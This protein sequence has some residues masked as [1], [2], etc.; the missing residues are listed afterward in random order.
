MNEKIKNKLSTI[1][2]SPGVYLMKDV[3][4]KIIY[5]GKAVNLKNRVSTYFNNSKKQVKVQAMVDS[6][7]NFD[8]IVVNS[9]YDALALENNLIKKYKPHYNILLKDSKTFP[10]IKLNL[11]TTFPFFEMTRH[12]EKDGAKYFGPYIGK[13][14]AK[15]ILELINFA[16]ELRNCKQKIDDEKLC[17][18]CLRYHLGNCLAPCIVKKAKTQYIINVKDA[19]D[20]LKGNEEKIV[21][22]L[23]LKMQEMV[24]NQNYEKAIVYR[25]NIR[26]LRSL[27]GQVVT[28]LNKT[29][30]LDIFAYS[31][32][33]KKI[34][35]TLCVIRAGKVIG[36]ENRIISEISETTF[37]DYIVQ[38]YEKNKLPKIVLLNEEI[39]LD[40]K[41]FI[42]DN[43]KV[44]ADFIVPLK[45]VKK[46]LLDMTL[47]NSE[48]TFIK[49]M[50]KNQLEENRTIN[51]V[52]NLQQILNL[53]SPPFR[54]EC[55]DVSHISGEY[56]VASMVVFVNG[57][58]EK[59]MYRKF[60]I[61]SVEGNNDFESLKETLTRRL[62]ELKKENNKDISLSVVPNLII[63]DGGKGQLSSVLEAVKELDESLFKEIPFIAIAKKEEEIFVP[64]KDAPVIISKNKMELQLIQRIRDESHRFAIMFHR[65]L[66]GKGMLKSIFDDITGVGEKKKKLL[67][68]EFKTMEE[69]KNATIEDFTKIKGINENLAKEIYNKIH[70]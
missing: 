68:Q 63:L 13:Y 65:S 45:G 35:I 53:P 4:G 61:K 37:Q 23:N 10:Y 46:K 57:K 29:E 43:S 8:Y 6:V 52:Y 27:H 11:N 2:T 16:F 50:N 36:F 15:T 49:E 60:K 47:K 19:V 67:Y 28:E 9:E 66:R 34:C 54:M 5:V 42:K 39:S 32:N 59:S 55:Y 31:S 30:D 38:Y 58:A 44:N 7:D 24:Q 33:G 62:L 22:R 25:D 3:S 41:N 14:K 20:Y 69:L 51:A 26:L 48:Q 12:V 40:A 64:S 56:K 18:P 21:A 70:E 17:K 1:S